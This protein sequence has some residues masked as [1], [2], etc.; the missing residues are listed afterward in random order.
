MSPLI[1]STTWLF[2][3]DHNGKHNWH[4]GASQVLTMILNAAGKLITNCIRSIGGHCMKDIRR[5]VASYESESNDN[6]N[7]KE[8]QKQL[9]SQCAFLLYHSDNEE[10]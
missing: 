1:V 6:W 2:V 7:V 4:S 9:W 10:P 8:Q 5:Q 3:I